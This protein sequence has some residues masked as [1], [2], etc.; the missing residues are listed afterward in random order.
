LGYGD[1]EIAKHLCD[2][3]GCISVSVTGALAE[4]GDRLLPFKDADYHW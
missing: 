2:L 4:K 1:R 3:V